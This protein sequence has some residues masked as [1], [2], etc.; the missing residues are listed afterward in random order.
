[1]RDRRALAF[2]AALLRVAN[3]AVFKLLLFL[4]YAG[5]SLP[6]ALNRS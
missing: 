5:V 4:R 2:A 3:R 6:F 1:V